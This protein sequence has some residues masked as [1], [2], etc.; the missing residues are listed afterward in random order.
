LANCFFKKWRMNFSF[1]GLKFP[2]F[3]GR[4]PS[5]RVPAAP[6][7]RA[8]RDGAAELVPT[9]AAS[10]RSASQTERER[11]A[12]DRILSGSLAVQVP[13]IRSTFD[14]AQQH[15]DRHPELAW[16]ADSGVAATNEGLALL[17]DA[18]KDSYS[19]QLGQQQFFPEFERSLQSLRCLSLIVDGSKSSHEEFVRHQCAPKL[20]F[21]QFQS[22]CAQWKKLLE[23][24]PELNANELLQAA[25]TALVL[26][27]M[28][29]S[30]KAREEMQALGID[31]PDHDDFY[32]HVMQTPEALK[33]LPSFV[34]LNPVQQNVVRSS[35]GLA[36]FGHITH[37]EGGPAMYANLTRTEAGVSSA[38]PFD[39]AMVVHMCDVAGALGHKNNQGSLTYNEHTHLAMQ[40]TIASCELLSSG[41]ALQAYHQY[42]SARAE[43]LGLSADIPSDQMLARLGAMLRLFTPQDGVALSAAE[44]DQAMAYLMPEGAAQ[45]PRTPTYMPAVLV[46][47]CNNKKLGES[48]QA[49][50]AQAIRIGIPYITAALQTYRAML[51]SGQM[52]DD[53]P[54]NFNP[55]AGVAATDP[56]ALMKQQVTI[57]PV[58]GAVTLAG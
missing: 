47:L 36:H 8:G 12:K 38:V 3:L 1:F 2:N 15:A 42:L 49:R 58:T 34:A 41:D 18:V 51:S 21:A 39:F 14:E 16:L 19:K 50:L 6:D 25:Q 23:N 53:V 32:G 57:N 48:Q 56:G 46:N 43:R 44:Q 33:Q 24:H 4:N 9:Q 31:D 7:L 40:D 55:I 52:G 5:P 29:K 45:L 30:P 28:G 13:P 26:G 37:C 22:M 35:A 54:L 10:A 27:D 17:T 11:A 20:S